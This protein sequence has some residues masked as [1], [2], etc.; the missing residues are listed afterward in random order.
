MAV[1]WRCTAAGAQQAN[2]L[3]GHGVG[4]V[5]IAVTVAAHPRSVAQQWRHTP[6]VI[7]VR[8]A[9]RIL[10][11]AVEARDEIEQSAFKVEQP[12]LDFIDHGWLDDPHLIGLP[13]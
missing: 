12:V 8:S 13:Q 9:Q 10:Q 3:K 11:F 2:R 5:R 4:D 1:M 6:C 7:R